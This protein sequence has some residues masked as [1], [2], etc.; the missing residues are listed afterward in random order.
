MRGAYDGSRKVALTLR[1]D[2]LWEVRYS[3]LPPGGRL[4]APLEPEACGDR[5][6]L[7]PDWREA[8]GHAV[9]EVLVIRVP[10]A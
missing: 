5:A 6:T 4:L 8:L 7:G 10:G 9:T 1:Y 2:G 3:H